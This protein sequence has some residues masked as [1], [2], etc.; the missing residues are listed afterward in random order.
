[1]LTHTNGAVCDCAE[2]I[3]TKCISRKFVFVIIYDGNEFYSSLDDKITTITDTYIH[4]SMDKVNIRIFGYV[5]VH[6]YITQ[7]HA[8]GKIT[9]RFHL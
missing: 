2:F 5:L 6:D 4:D 1:M 3:C 8:T 9:N 7:K